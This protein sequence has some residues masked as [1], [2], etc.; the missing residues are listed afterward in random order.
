M[1][2]R[3]PSSQDDDRTATG[4]EETRPHRRGRPRDPAADPAI[5]RATL[6]LLTEVGV[7]GAKTN[8]IANRSGCSKSTI[9]RRWPTRELLILDAL[10]MASRVRPD[11]GGSTIDPEPELGSPLHAAAHRGAKTIDSRLFRAV[12][13]TIARE[14]LADSAIGEQFR[15]DVFV[16]IRAAAKA[17]LLEAIER[18]E[19]APAIDPDLL[20]DLIYG[21]LLYRVLFGEPVDDIVAGDLA[22]LVMN[23]AAGPQYRK[24]GRRHGSLTSAQGR[25]VA[26]RGRARD[27]SM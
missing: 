11:E 22:D 24:A 25:D 2:D 12:F 9:Y 15:T 14:L 4:A 21:G 19:I 27:S 18:G 6:E 3:I 16:P 1:Q 23:G 17:R 20:F 8:A 26:G 10:R 7:D 5:L 13:P